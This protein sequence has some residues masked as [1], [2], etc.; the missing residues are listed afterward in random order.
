MASRR[1]RQPGPPPALPVYL[2][3]GDPP[4]KRAVL[5]AALRLFVRKGLGETTIRDIA[6]EAGFTNPVLFKYFAGRD[7]LAAFLFERCYRS[8]SLRL[9]GALAPGGSFARQ[10]SVLVA[11]FLESMDQDLDAHLFVQENLRR[12]WPALAPELR[13]HSVVRIA[14]QLFEAGKEQGAV[15]PALDTSL[16]T[17]AL[18][19]TLGQL[20]RALYF[21]EAPAARAEELQARTER[22]L[23]NMVRKRR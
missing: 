16:L 11:V 2:D 20:S 12:M 17:V 14:G 10:L 15:D 22:L 6:A 1:R 8:F 13:R 18:L 23:H 19:G 7:E 3:Q 4:S 5:S 21:G 9:Q